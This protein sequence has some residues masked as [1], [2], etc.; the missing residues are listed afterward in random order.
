[1]LAQLHF[2][3]G[4]HQLVCLGGR[5]CAAC[6]QSTTRP[7][8]LIVQDIRMALPFNHLYGFVLFVQDIQATLLKKIYPEM[9]FLVASA[10]YNHQA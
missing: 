3:D 7:L 9:G 1:M 10:D 8:D 4:H 6:P 2:A 5:L